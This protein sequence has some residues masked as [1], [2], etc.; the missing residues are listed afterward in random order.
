[1]SRK[2]GM[3]IFSN[4][5]TSLDGKI[6]PVR[7]AL[8]PLGTAEDRRHMIRLR[9]EADAILFG[10]STLRAYRKYCHT[11]GLPN[12]RAEP[13]NVVLSSRLEGISPDWPFFKARGVR[14]ILLVS[15][16]AP[17]AR[18]KRFER[19]CEVI[20][21][22]KPSAK[23]PLVLQVIDAL[24]KR[25]VS[26]LLVEG[27]GGVMALFAEKNLIDEYHVT[28][29]PRIL[30]GA[31]APTLVDGAGMSGPQSLKLTL[32]QCR[33]LGDELYLVYSR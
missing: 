17:V 6:A 7:P 4:L 5:A 26:R 1:M 15:F 12:G 21:L 3:F 25:E 16:D 11:P 33:V 27:G 10:A 22:S 28:L 24:E 30:G 32:R 14:R 13:V 8:F 18:I 19:T 29:T 20:R 31:S 2:R 9:R 23:K